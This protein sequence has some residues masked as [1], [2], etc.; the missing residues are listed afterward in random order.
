LFLRIFITKK[1]VFATIFIKFG[2]S[3]ITLNNLNI[4][5]KSLLLIG[6]II[7]SVAVATAQVKYQNG[8][9]SYGG[10][11][12][13]GAATTWF[14]SSHVFTS[15]ITTGQF[16][17]KPTANSTKIGSSSG[18]LRIERTNGSL[19]EIYSGRVYVEER[20]SSSHGTISQASAKIGQL[21]PVLMLP[22]AGGGTL[23]G[24]PI[25]VI[26]GFPAG[27]VASELGSV[28]PY[29]VVTTD[30]NKKLIDYAV[31]IP[32]LVAAMQEQNA[33]IATLEQRIQTLEN[34]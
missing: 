34:E 23:F 30:D 12:V 11:A 14:G 24:S 7:C 16:W 33:Y 19:Q 31:I 3:T 2:T 32:Y 10:T 18:V 25:Q 20:T 26:S 22:G 1:F 8:V 15:G 17:I 4:M 28:I 6:I 29:S 5:K 27:F 21:N 13:S 9:L